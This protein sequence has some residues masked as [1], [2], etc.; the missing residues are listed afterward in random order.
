MQIVTFATFVFSILTVIAQIGIIF[1]LVSSFF[2][3]GIIYKVRI[4]FGKHALLFGFIVALICTLGSLFYSEIAHFT[5]CTLCW[6][7]RV[8]MYPQAIILAIAYA[9][10][11]RHAVLYSIVMSMLG[12][13][14]A[15]YHYLLQINVIGEI[16]PCTTVGYSVSCAEKFVM[17]FGYITIPL[18]SLSGFLLILSL[19]LTQ[20]NYQAS[21]K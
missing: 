1:L 17:T 19:M 20:R 21:K 6:Y 11:D 7:Q 14:I 9:K 10:K 3:R 13:G 18:M 15:L 5:P 4:F 12:A 2:K 16:L 8:F